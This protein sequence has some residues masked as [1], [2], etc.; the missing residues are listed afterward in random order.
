VDNVPSDALR[1]GSPNGGV[2]SWQ[3][4][5]T[6]AEG[7]TLRLQNVSGVACQLQGAANGGGGNRAS[8]TVV[9]IQ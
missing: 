8:L 6:T 1:R 5:I 7:S 9:K 4:L 3:G 2:V